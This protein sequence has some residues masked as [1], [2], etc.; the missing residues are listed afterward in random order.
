[1][2]WEIITKVA[3]KGMTNIVSLKKN[4]LTVY[5]VKNAVWGNQSRRSRQAKTVT[6]AV[7]ER[8]RTVAWTTVSW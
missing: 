8:H 1:M 3:S 4:L 6:R 5:C 2:T 7:K